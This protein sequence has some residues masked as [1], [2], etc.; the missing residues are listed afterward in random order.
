MTERE[1]A[2]E[3]SILIKA[4]FTAIAIT[5]KE[6]RRVERLIRQVARSLAVTLPDGTQLPEY[7]VVFWSCTQG[8]L[9]Q[10]GEQLHDE[11]NFA[12]A[13]E[14]MRGHRERVLFV[15]R[16]AHH[17]LSGPENARPQR[18]LRD[19]AK[20]FKGTKPDEARVVILLSPVLEVPAELA[21]DVHT[22]EWPLPSR[23]ELKAVL[24]ETLK[25]VA[26]AVKA[27][28]GQ[29][30]EEAVLTAS[31]G[32]TAEDA[33]AAFAR[34]IVAK[35]TLDPEMIAEQ[36]KQLIAKS[37][38]LEILD[39]LAGGF[40]N[41]AGLEVLKGDLDDFRLAYSDEGRAYG[42]H[43]PKGVFLFG[44]QGC[45]KS[46][47][48]QGLAG[49]WRVQC[50]R[51]S[52][53]GLFGGLLGET[54]KNFREVRKILKVVGRAVVLVDEIEKALGGGGE[55]D[56][57]TTSRIRSELLTWLQ[58]RDGSEVFLVGTANDIESLT[59]SCPELIRKGRWDEMYFVSLPHEDERAEAFRV[60]MRKRKGPAY[61]DPSK[62]D[63]KRL[64]A[65]TDGFSG[66]EIEAV[67]ERAMLSGFRHQRPVDLEDLTVQIR[68]TTPLSKTAG[69]KLEW[70]AKWARDRAKMASRRMTPSSRPDRHIE[71][72]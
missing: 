43:P 54:E 8:F 29:V 17:Y 63:L 56:G 59:G 35:R 72:A 12:A 5:S 21:G 62:L 36:K 48:A 37:G 7:K 30:D 32:L 42:L 71:V 11:R 39:P 14:W 19:T 57:N 1:T 70:M 10:E 3:L 47:I 50:I 61:P 18:Q 34:S 13:L 28:M 9:D 49:D 46:L 40:A 68:S 6:E 24:T 66:A 25:G 2:R 45:G 53:A 15:M 52:P 55:Q 58:S 38:A 23:D 69:E 33:Y 64:V 60:H 67:V 26:S 65:L 41:V 27:D 31:V 4:K 16:D 20:F 51:F 44:A 22:L